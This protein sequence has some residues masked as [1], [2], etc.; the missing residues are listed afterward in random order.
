MEKLADYG[1]AG[2]VIAASFGLLIWLIK[3]YSKEVR[4]A[5]T[6]F[7]HVMDQITK[8]NEDLSKKNLDSWNENVK[9][10]GKMADRL[11]NF[12]RPR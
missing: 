6:D 7:T 11:D 4:D 12:T 5:R 9:A 8:T 1:L 10:M 2:A 3:F